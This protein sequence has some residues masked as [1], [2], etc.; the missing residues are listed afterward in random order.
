MMEDKHDANEAM[1]NK[2]VAEFN[3]MDLQNKRLELEIN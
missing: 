1:H 3:E 2:M